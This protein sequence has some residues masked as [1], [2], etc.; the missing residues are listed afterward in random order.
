MCL[1]LFD[2][3]FVVV[4]IA[5]ISAFLCFDGLRGTSTHHRVYRAED[6]LT[7]VNLL[8]VNKRHIERPVGMNVSSFLRGSCALV[9]V[10]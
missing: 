9:T 6:A 3:S 7:R 8:T 5:R 10:T 4:F 2:F 1:F